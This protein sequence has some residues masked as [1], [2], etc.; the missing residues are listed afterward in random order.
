[1]GEYLG[2]LPSPTGDCRPSCSRAPILRP[3]HLTG[4]LQPR[5][6]LR[7]VRGIRPLFQL[8]THNRCH[9]WNTRTPYTAWAPDTTILSAFT[10]T[11][12]HRLRNQQRTWEGTS[13]RELR[14]TH[15]APVLPPFEQPTDHHLLLQTVIT[16]ECGWQ[17]K[18][19]TN[20]TCACRCRPCTPEATAASA[21]HSTGRGPGWS[22]SSASLP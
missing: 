2:G 19:K 14:R 10:V 22:V 12:A 13:E 3:A 16:Q 20:T 7:S 1:V 6:G 11:C 18:N 21:D 9:T 8:R 5:P 15:C 4:P 17:D